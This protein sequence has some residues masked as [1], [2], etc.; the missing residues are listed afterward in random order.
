MKGIILIHG[1]LTNID[2]FKNLIPDL[3]IEYDEVCLYTVPGHT[4]PP[5]YKLFNVND[6][7]NTLLDTYDRLALSCEEIDCIGFSMGGA[8]ATYLQSVRDI[9]KLVLLAPANKYLNFSL[10]HNRLQF[11]KKVKKESKL[12]DD[13]S[14]KKEEL[15]ILT[16][17]DKESLKIMLKELLPNYTPHNLQTFMQI[18]K[19]CNKELISISVPVLIIWGKLDQ[20]VPQNSVKY[21]YDIAINKKELIIYDDISHLMLN[22]ENYQKIVNDI[23]KFLKE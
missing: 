22:S 9:R 12:R 16:Y 14:Y 8:L 5:K 4:I 18:I 10:F 20:L 19:K 21:L 3:E 23:M 7:F 13:L 1:F 11:I 6:T 17:N 2:D 15:D